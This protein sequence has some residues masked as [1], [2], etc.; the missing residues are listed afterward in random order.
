MRKNVESVHSLQLIRLPNG[1]NGVLAFLLGVSKQV[2][3]R[4]YTARVK[5]LKLPP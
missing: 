3:H 2:W 1:K 5:P 4:G